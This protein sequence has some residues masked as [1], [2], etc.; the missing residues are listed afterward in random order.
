MTEGTPEHAEVLNGITAIDTQI[1]QVNATQ[2]KFR[3]GVEDLAVSAFGD[4]LGDLT[5]G[6]KNFKAAFA[7]M[8]KS[9]VAGV[10]RMIAQELALRA[11]KSLM[12][13]WGGG[14][15]GPVVKESIPIGS[16]HTGGMAGSS[17]RKIRIS[18]LL[19]GHAPRYHNGGIAG[20]KPDEVPAILQTGER[21]LSR[22]QTAAYEAAKAGAAGAG[23]AARVTTPIVAIGDA[24][25][26]NALAGAAGESVVMTHVRNNWEG[27]SR[28]S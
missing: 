16:L 14:A 17:A 12:G 11:I 20:L 4:F 18:P 9:F 6:A 27:L 7:D 25:V 23:A 21:V 19:F 28:G 15:V 5:T 3:Q 26:A 2:Q 1:A 22:R 24:A 10:A 8:V 13:A